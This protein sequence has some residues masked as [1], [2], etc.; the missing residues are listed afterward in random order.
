MN[1]HLFAT[2]L[3]VLASVS[4]FADSFKC[5]AESVNNLASLK[6]ST[7]R[8][9]AG[10]PSYFDKLLDEIKE[11]EFGSDKTREVALNKAKSILQESNWVLP[12]DISKPVEAL[13]ILSDEAGM[14]E[15][16]YSILLQKE[17]AA[18]FAA[19][20]P[21]GAKDWLYG[22]VAGIQKNEDGSWEDFELAPIPD[23]RLVFVEATRD[24]PKG[25]IKSAWR[26]EAGKCNWRFTIPVGLKATVCVN[27]MC[28]RYESGE[29]SVEIKNNQE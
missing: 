26:Y 27:G 22:M 7:P 15:V 16:A 18:I 25:V 19:I 11:D 8:N 20:D 5:G 6:F 14:C 23:K 29:Y 28:M 21:S 13:S 12:K 10:E 1:K 24:T 17:N 3:A 4:A 2:C 9:L